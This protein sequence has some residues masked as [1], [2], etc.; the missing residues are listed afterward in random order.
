MTTRGVLCLHGFTATPF[1]FSW[2]GPRLEQ[3]GFVVSAPLLPGHGNG[4]AALDRTGWPDW[5]AGADAA[6]VD[7]R[8]RCDSV[9][10]VGQSLGGLL[11]LH[12][13]R[14]RGDQLACVASLGAPLW[15]PT[16]AALAARA[17]GALGWPF[18]PKRGGPDILDT[19]AVA[20]APVMKVF[21]PRA[22]ASVERFMGVVR[23]EIDLVSIPTFVA[24]AEHDHVAPP[25][26]AAELARRVGAVKLVWLPRSYHIGPL[27][28]D[29]ELLADELI[30]FLT[31]RMPS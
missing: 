18:V 25:A 7:L 21:P 19:T 9:A 29:R 14:N 8:S 31:E 24:H 4:P 15:L 30:G 3:R 20:G 6:F 28:V 27:D 10:V 12:L 11:A 17:V 22:L 23:A 13:A 1:E 5:F 16:W 2:L 26:C